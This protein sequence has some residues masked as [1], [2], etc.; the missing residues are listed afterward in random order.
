MKI[1]LFLR[2]LKGVGDDPHSCL[3][4]NGYLESYMQSDTIMLIDKEHPT[5]ESP[6]LQIYTLH[7]SSVG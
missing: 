6:D 4:C 3:R 5:P 1:R 2:L 7:D